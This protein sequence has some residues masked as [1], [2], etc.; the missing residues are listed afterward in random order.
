MFPAQQPEFLYKT[1]KT[2]ESW[3]ERVFS[4][5]D[6]DLEVQPILISF[7]YI[8][9]FLLILSSCLGIWFPDVINILASLIS[10]Y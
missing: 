1:W 10:P 9:S 6:F 5:L 8:S 7:F 2:A 4:R 3:Y